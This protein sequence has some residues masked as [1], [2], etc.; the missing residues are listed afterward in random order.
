MTAWEDILGRP[1]TEEFNYASSIKSF[2]Y[3]HKFPNYF[4]TVR[5][6]HILHDIYLVSL[7]NEDG[8]IVG[9]Y[10]ALFYETT[11]MCLTAGFSFQE[12]ERQ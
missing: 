10:E 5:C 8:D 6:Q 11:V 7:Y 2:T 3:D 4:N 1:Y 9:I 12:D